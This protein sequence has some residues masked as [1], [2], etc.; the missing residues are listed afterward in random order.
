M[1][2]ILHVKSSGN[3]AAEAKENFAFGSGFLLKEC[4]QYVK[5]SEI[6]YVKLLSSQNFDFFEKKKYFEVFKFFWTSE[7]FFQK[8]KFAGILPA[9]CRQTSFSEKKIQMSKKI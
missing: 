3:I 2:A 4:N 1:P 9:I 7:F 8:M 6:R 5:K